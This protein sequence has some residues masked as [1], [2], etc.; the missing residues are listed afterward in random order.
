MFGSLG[1]MM[2]LL[3]ELK[4]KLPEMREKLDSTTYTAESCGVRATV[5]GMK[6][7]VDLQ[8]DPALLTGPNSAPGLAEATKAA[9]S[10]AQELASKAA[11]EAMKELTG[12]MEIPGMEGLL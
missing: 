8:I 9:V 7:V 11:A 12:G 4:T 1:K 2:K 3:S 10:A 6:I 5:N